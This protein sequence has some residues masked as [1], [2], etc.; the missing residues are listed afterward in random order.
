VVDAFFAALAPA[1]LDL[2]DEVLAAHQADDARLA[3]QYTDRLVRAEYEA[4]LAQRQYQAVDP[5]NRLVA[6]ELE[7]RWEVALRTV[8]EARAAAEGFANRPAVPHLPTALKEQLRDLGQYLPQLWRSQQLTFSQQKELLRSLIR[9]VI[10]TRPVPDTVV[11]K[12]VWVSGAVTPL[13]IYPP[14]L[15]AADTGRYENSSRACW[16]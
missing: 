15:R 7:R 8:A 11:A 12:V 9:H 16:R 3:Q 14:I 6:A 1:E 13:N 4:R 10:V 5:D 2:L